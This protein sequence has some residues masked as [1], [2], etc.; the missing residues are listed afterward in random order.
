MSED[1][2]FMD[3]LDQQFKSIEE[4]A[5]Q[6][7]DKVDRSNPAVK[8]L[9][10]SFNMQRVTLIQTSFGK[11]YLQGLPSQETYKAIVS[12]KVNGT[13]LLAEGK[14]LGYLRFSDAKG[15]AAE[16]A[17]YLQYRNAVLEGLYGKALLDHLQETWGYGL[18]EVLAVLMG[19]GK[20]KPIVLESIKGLTL[21]AGLKTYVSNIRNLEGSLLDALPEDSNTGPI[22]YPK[23]VI[24]QAEQDMLAFAED[25]GL[26]VISL[27]DL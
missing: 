11:L 18:K 16:Q 6:F 26:P 19:E 8:A 14:A 13:D 22:L 2:S 7:D 12:G 27:D 1:L 23:S 25:N 20:P 3:E 24:Q 4:E 21:A 17:G 10:K 5:K 15:A 9:T